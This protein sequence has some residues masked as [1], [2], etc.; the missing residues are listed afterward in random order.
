MTWQRPL[1]LLGNMCVAIEKNG[2]AKCKATQRRFVVGEAKVGI[3][4][5]TATAWITLTSIPAILSPV[6]AVVPP[7]KT[8]DFLTGKKWMALE[9]I[10][11]LSHSQK[12][13]LQDALQA[14]ASK[15]SFKKK[16]AREGQPVSKTRKKSSSA[17][18]RDMQSQPKLGQV[19]RSKGRVAWKWAARVCYGTLQPSR[20]SKTHCYATTKNRKTKT[21]AKGKDY[22]WMRA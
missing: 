5:H 7:S 4:S 17:T 20:E 10:E 1:C 16:S 15:T 12:Q 11:T 19:T 2:R 22:W 9:G 18:T 21:L 13:D 6:F 3:R 14:A 8:Q